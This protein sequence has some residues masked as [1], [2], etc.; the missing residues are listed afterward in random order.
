M[1]AAMAVEGQHLHVHHQPRQNVHHTA[2]AVQ[3]LVAARHPRPVEA[4]SDV[5][6]VVIANRRVEVAV[7]TPYDIGDTS[8]DASDGQPARVTPPVRACRTWCGASTSCPSI[9]TAC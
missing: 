5:D 1:R 6:D 7:C 4:D 3:R 8:E 9:D 2:D